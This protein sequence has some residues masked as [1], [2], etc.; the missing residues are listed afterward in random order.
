M[1]YKAIK[2][3]SQ[4][5]KLRESGIR[6]KVRSITYIAEKYFIFL[7]VGSTIEVIFLLPQLIEKYKEKR[8]NICMVFIDLEKIYDE[9]FKELI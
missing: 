8:K 6:R 4:T 9:I 3:I 1:N 2:L 7:P 5:M